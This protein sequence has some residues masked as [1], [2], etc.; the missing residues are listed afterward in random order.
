MDH[1]NCSE[2]RNMSRISP[3]CPLC[4][5]V[6][7]VKPGENIDCKVNQ[8][9]EWGC[10]IFQPMFSPQMREGNKCSYPRCKILSWS[11]I[12]CFHC[13]QKFCSKHHIPEEHN[14]RKLLAS[15]ERRRE[16]LSY[17]S[18]S[19]VTENETVCEDDNSIKANMQ[20]I[21]SEELVANRKIKEK[22]FAFTWEHKIGR[23]IDFIARK[24]GFINDNNI[25]GQKKLCLFLEGSSEPLMMNLTLSDLKAT[26][27]NMFP[28]KFRLKYCTADEFSSCCSSSSSSS[29]SSSC[30][31]SPSSLSSSSSS[32]NIPS[33]SSM[34]M[35]SYFCNLFTPSSPFTKMVK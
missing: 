1:H 31:S 23:V 13:E 8:H 12:S 24:E 10:R 7:I 3:N 30:C 35:T 20:I 15:V 18:R 29:C 27:R 19:N 16:C 17:M 28:T 34:L 14:C 21:F 6:V 9:I 2:F 5:Q 11:P 32:M 4:N 25:P 22:S 33:P 26:Q